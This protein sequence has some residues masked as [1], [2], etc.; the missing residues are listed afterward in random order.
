MN[1]KQQGREN[2]RLVGNAE[3]INYFENSCPLEFQG[4]PNHAENS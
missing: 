1:E 4:A 3:I 2:T